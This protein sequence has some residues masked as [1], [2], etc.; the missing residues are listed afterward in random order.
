MMDAVA[1]AVPIAKDVGTGADAQMERAATLVRTAGR[2]HAQLG[3]GLVD[4]LGIAE[5]GF[6]LNFDDHAMNS[7]QCNPSRFCTALPTRAQR[8]RTLLRNE[9]KS[10]CRI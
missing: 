2:L 8:S 3:D 1:E 5:T 6:V 7:P 10:P 9:C 4:R